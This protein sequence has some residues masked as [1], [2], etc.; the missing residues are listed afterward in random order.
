MTEQPPPAPQDNTEPSPPGDGAAGA[1]QDAPGSLA[2]PSDDEEIDVELPED[3]AEASFSDDDDDDDDEK[4]DGQGTRGVR[5]VWTGYGGA[6]RMVPVF[7]SRSS[8][9]SDLCSGQ[10]MCLTGVV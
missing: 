4:E 2:P 10:C 7:D 9:L 5:G 3:E 8:R 6:I 1:P